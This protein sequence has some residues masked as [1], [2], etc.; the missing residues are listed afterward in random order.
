MALARSGTAELKR[1]SRTESESGREQQP[2][3]HYGGP[4]RLLYFNLALKGDDAATRVNALSLERGKKK[5]PDDCT[6]GTIVRLLLLF[7]FF[8]FSLFHPANPVTESAW[9]SQQDHN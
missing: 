9:Q 1:M 6:T 8:W 4:S 5:C 2:L 7:L 3:L